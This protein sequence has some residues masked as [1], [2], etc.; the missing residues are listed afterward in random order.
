MNYV[1]YQIPDVRDMFPRFFSDASA[2]NPWHAATDTNRSGRPD[3]TTGEVI[4]TL[5]HDELHSHDH[6]TD[7]QPDTIGSGS[8][9]DGITQT[10]AN[11]IVVANTGGTETRPKNFLFNAIVKY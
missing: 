11:D 10:T 1:F 2:N 5:Q 8:G 4:G 9:E 7:Y 6:T 3:Q